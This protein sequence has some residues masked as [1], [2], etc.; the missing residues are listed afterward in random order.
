[1]RISDW[2]SDVCSSDLL[3][4]IQAGGAD[5]LQADAPRVGGIT[6]FL[7]IC[8]LAE[9]HRLGLAPHFVMEIHLHLAAAYPGEPW[10]EHFEWL[11]PVFNERLEIRDGRMHV[12]DRP[13]LGFTLSEAAASRTREAVEFGRRP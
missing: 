13:G 4:L 2:S 12:P 9:H 10:V 7:K 1:M 5:F 3:R 6:P 11:E 8:T